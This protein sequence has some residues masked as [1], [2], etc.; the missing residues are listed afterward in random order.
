MILAFELSMPSVGSWNGKWSGE[1]DMYVK[2]VNIPNRNGAL[3]K[4]EA[5]LSNRCYDYDF[6]DGWRAS[7]CVN[8]V[9]PKDATKLRRK[10]KGF[11]GYDWMVDSIMEHLKIYTPTDQK[12]LAH[13][14]DKY[15]CETIE[16]NQ[17]QL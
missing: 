10:T 7:V 17:Q 14:E 9:D 15:V 11:C 6:G 12:L 4:A 13:Q 2:V 16:S 3:Q 5:I 1:K 8:K